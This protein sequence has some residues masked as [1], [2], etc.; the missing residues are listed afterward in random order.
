MTQSGH[1]QPFQAVSPIRLSRYDACPEPE[2][3]H[4]AARIHRVFG[5][6]AA[7]WPLA[8]RAQQPAMPV[9]GYLSA[10]IARRPAQLDRGVSARVWRKPVRR[11]SERGHRISLGDGTIRPAA[12]DGGRT[13]RPA[14]RGDRRDR[15]R[16]GQCGGQGSDFDHPDRLRHRRRSGQAAAWSQASTGRAATSPGSTLF[17]ARARSQSGS[18]CC[19]SSCRKRRTVGDA[20]QS[21]AI[22]NADRQL[23]DVQAARGRLDWRYTS[24]RSQHTN[25]RS[26][27]AFAAIAH[28][29]SAALMVGTDPFF[30]TRRDQLVAIDGAPCGARRCIQFREFVEAGG[31]MS[32]G[33][34]LHRRVSPGRRL[35]R[36]H[37]QRRQARPTCRSCSRP[38]S[39]W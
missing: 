5:G 22:R 12:G 35:Y 6:A 39:S 33:A 13:G 31:L 14:G 11:R 25:A 27:R 1:R 37:P 24:L 4:E 9:I 36:P 30:N 16:A 3:G 38:S 23:R 28:S 8:A 2:G 18:G 20:R 10:R 26:T 19:T 32:Y 17:N 29:A 7:A 34:D 21:A 15:R